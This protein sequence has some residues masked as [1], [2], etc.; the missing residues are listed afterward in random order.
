MLEEKQARL[1]GL[2][3]NNWKKSK[4]KRRQEAV[5]AHYGLFL[6]PLTQP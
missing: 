6:A 2:L 1:K 4:R 3:L 5:A